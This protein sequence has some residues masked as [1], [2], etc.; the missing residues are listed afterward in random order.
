MT[1]LSSAQASDDLGL[2]LDEK[3]RSGRIS[4]GLRA[5][6]LALAHAGARIA[7]LIARGPLGAA[8]AA[9]TGL[10]NQGGDAQKALDILANEIVVEA[11]RTTPAAYFLSEEIDAIMTLDPGGELAIAVDPLDGS[12]NIDANITIGT[13]FSIFAVSA[14]GASASF[15]RPGREQLAAGYFIYGPHTAL[16]LTTGEGTDLYVLDGPAGSFR[17]AKAR[18][19]IPASSKEFAINASN[20]RHWSDPIRNFVDDCLDGAEGPRGKDYNMRWVASLIAETHR[21]LSRGGVFLYPSDRRPSY[22]HGRLRHV[23]EAAPIA[24]VVEQAGGLA[25]DGR[26]A[27]LD[28]VP[29]DLHDR[30]PLIFGSSQEVTLIASYHTHPEFQRQASPLFAQRGLFRS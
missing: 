14:D 30:T 8:L 27:I 12:S 13:I 10:A 22:E 29:R 19:A 21:I 20:R 28:R 25:T 9:D 7:A 26:T 18:I 15:L 5:T 11:L 16:V 1:A 23:Y 24:M 17:M 2:V 6:I 3:V 4:P